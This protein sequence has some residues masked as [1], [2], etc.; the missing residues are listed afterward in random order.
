M[1]QVVGDVDALEGAAHRRR[2]ER[3]SRDDL[4]PGFRWDRLRSA[5]EAAHAGAAFEQRVQETPADIA[6]RAGD[7]DLRCEADAGLRVHR[8][9][10]PVTASTAATRSLPRWSTPTRLQSSSDAPAPEKTSRAE[11]ASRTS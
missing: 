4:E 7:E 2:V 3:V 11:L 10:L 5:R 6:G 8:Q 9:F 1:D